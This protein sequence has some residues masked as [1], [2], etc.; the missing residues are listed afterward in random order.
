VSEQERYRP[1]SQWTGTHVAG[2]D[3]R[4]GGGTTGPGARPS[5]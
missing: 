4:G 1:R 3:G 2:R 5:F